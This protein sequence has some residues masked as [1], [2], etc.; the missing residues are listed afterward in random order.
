MNPIQMNDWNIKDIILVVLVFQLI[1][2]ITAIIQTNNVHFPIIRELSSFIVLFFLNGVLI[3]RIFNIHQLGNIKTI[4]YSVGLS[5]ASLMFFGMLID[6]VYPLLGITKPISLIPLLVTFTLFAGFLSI[7]AYLRDSIYDKPSILNT[8]GNNIPILIFLIL[9]FLSIYGTYIMNYYQNSTLLIL[10]FIIIA[11]IPFLVAFDKF[12]PREIYPLAILSIALTLIFSSS[13]FTNY[14]SGWDINQEFYFSNLVVTSSHW[15]SSIP[16]LLNAMLSLV[17]TVPIF[18]KISGLNIVNIFKIVYPAIFTLVPLALYQIFK[19]QTNARMSFMGCFLFVSIFMFFLEMP[20]LARQEIGELF[21]VLMI[22]LMVETQ[23]NSKK[24]SLLTIIFIP[25]LLVSHYSMDYIYIF[26]VL[27]AYIVILIRN[28]NLPER[29]NRLGTLPIINYFFVKV[30]DEDTFKMRYKLQLVLLFGVTIIY[31]L[32]VSSS[33][34]FHLTVSTIHNLISMSYLF[35]FNPKALMVV[36]IV[37][38]AHSHLRTIALILD[39]IIEGLIGLG[40]LFLL[41]RRTGL[42]FNENYGLF[43]VMSFF[44]LILVLVVPFLAGALNPERFY[45]IA[46]IFLSIFFVVGFIGIFNILNR[47]LGYKWSKKSIYHTSLKF[48][49]LFLAV[50]L[51]FNSGVVY[52]LLGDTPSNL[53]LH[54]SMDGPK[55]N[56]QEVNSAQ[57][58]ATYR[59]N[60]FVYADEYK[61]LLLNGYIPYNQS[62]PI[63]F[64]L[65]ASNQSYLFFGT[66]NIQNDKIGVQQPGVSTLLYEEYKKPLVVRNKIFDDGGSQIW[67]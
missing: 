40:V 50:S 15:D 30:K 43:S 3:L 5:I 38:S 63:N 20:Y 60:N 48:M 34:L 10:M 25:A 31:Y 42:K 47:I 18:S 53:S 1:I 29:Y 56:T 41:A 23:L 33:V 58:I 57:W 6:L 7:L 37:T 11:F 39:L 59:T 2:W 14:I 27:T 26:L 36:G 61:S 49:A 46:L 54:S 17:I 8:D 4:L 64:E 9:P 62:A 28:L 22:M 66:Y 12:I 65:I 44:L 55:F 52:E 21:F 13:L 24:L 32:L 67:H 16:D 35:L 19:N 45:Q 51:I